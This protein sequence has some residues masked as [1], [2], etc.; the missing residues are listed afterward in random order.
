MT[1]LQKNAHYVK[2]YSFAP[3]KHYNKLKNLR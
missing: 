1:V 3:T 2:L